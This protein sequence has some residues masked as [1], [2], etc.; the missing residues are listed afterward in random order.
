MV[1]V[2]RTYISAFSKRFFKFSL[3]ASLDILLIRVRSETPTSFFLVLS[4]TAFLIC[5]WPPLLEALALPVLP[6]VSACFLRP[7]RFV[8]AYS[9]VSTSS[10][11]RKADN[12]PQSAYH[13]YQP[14]NTPKTLLINQAAYVLYNTSHAGLKADSLI[15]SS[16]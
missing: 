5:G 11:K 7:A 13:C 16:R 9:K 10:P 8:T 1:T 2:S 14:R 4:N 6:M 3:I 15:S 12:E